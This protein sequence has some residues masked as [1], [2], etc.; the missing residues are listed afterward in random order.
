MPAMPPMTGTDLVTNPGRPRIW[1]AKGTC[2]STDLSFGDEQ[3]LVAPMKKKVNRSIRTQKQALTA[4]RWGHAGG[5]RPLVPGELQARGGPRGDREGVYLG[6]NT[7]CNGSQQAKF[8]TV[9]RPANSL[10]R[11]RK[12]NKIQPSRLPE[13]PSW[14]KVGSGSAQGRGGVPAQ[15]AGGTTRGGRP[16]ALPVAV[17]HTGT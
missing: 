10:P 17:A 2:I 7:P 14:P 11:G 3:H 8:W 6:K 15:R 13:W 1:E 12:R 16:A 5:R 9:E 4:S